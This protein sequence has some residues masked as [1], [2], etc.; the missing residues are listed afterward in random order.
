[1]VVAIPV[2]P[3]P[4]DEARTLDL[5]DALRAYEPGA[6]DVVLVDDAT[7]GPRRWPD[8]VTVLPNPRAGRGIPTL[9]GTTVATLTAL[10]HAHAHH[11][12]DWVL[13]LDSDALVVGP[14][15]DAVEAAWQPGDGVLGSCHRTPH[16]TARDVSDIRHEVARHARAVWATRTPARRPLYVRPAEPHVR[17][18]L[19]QALDAGYD[20]GEHCI[21]AGC[22]ISAALVRATA[23]RGWLDEPRRWLHAKLGDD[24]VL[25]AMARAC[26]LRLR[27]LHAVFGVQHVGLPGTPEELLARGHAVVHAVKGDGQAEARATFRAARA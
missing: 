24:M 13:R 1:M 19:R 23:D 11:P 5:L 20:P 26:G 3:A 8:G 17:G 4:E 27:D 15:Q 22:A 21:A 18:V 12:G 7:G 2:G 10:R 6:R 14:V 9:G 25:G 16:G